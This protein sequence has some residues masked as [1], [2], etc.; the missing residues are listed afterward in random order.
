MIPKVTRLLGATFPSR[1]SADA[2]TIQEAAQTAVDP[3]A[4]RSHWRRFQ[5]FGGVHPDFIVLAMV[6]L[7]SLQIQKI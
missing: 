7:C 4:A 1:P 5:R 3:A 2:G 6:V